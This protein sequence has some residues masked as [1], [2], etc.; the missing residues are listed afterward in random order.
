[1]RGFAD[2]R[3]RLAWAVER[4]VLWGLDT[5]TGDGFLWMRDP[6]R[7]A[8][9]D[10]SA[11]WR[12]HLTWWLAANGAGLV[13]AAAVAPPGRPDAGALL[14]GRGGSGKSTLALACGAAGWAV[15]SDDYVAVHRDA[16]GWTAAG[17]YRWAKA[18]PA[19]I[20]LLSIPEG[21]L[22]PGIDHLGKS[23]IDLPSALGDRGAVPTGLSMIVVPQIVTDR[24][25]PARRLHPAAVTAA[26]GPSTVL[27]TPGDASAA[28][29]AVAQLAG[30][31]PGWALDVDGDVARTGPAALLEQIDRSMVPS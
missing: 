20:D 30:S 26:L 17:P 21:W 6:A 10:R 23:L 1:M 8:V 5:E 7:C 24:R 27:Q 14:V 29:H 13:H 11:P 25:G 15:T 16:S 31:L 2:G 18:S 19:T 12:P 4:Q 3:F 28:L 22:V 9:W